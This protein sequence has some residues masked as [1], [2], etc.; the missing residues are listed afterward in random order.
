MSFI[1]KEDRAMFAFFAAVL[2]LSL[3][4]LSLVELQAVTY[5]YHYRHSRAYENIMIG[6]LYLLFL[7]AALLAL[8]AVKKILRWKKTRSAWVALVLLALAAFP[9]YYVAHD[10]YYSWE[11]AILISSTVVDKDAESCYVVLQGAGDAFLLLYGTPTEINLLDVGDHIGLTEYRYKR[12]SY[13]QLEGVGVV[14]IGYIRQISEVNT[15]GGERAGKGAALPKRP[16]LY[17]S[18]SERGDSR[19]LK[20][21]VKHFL[22][23]Y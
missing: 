23:Q 15:W 5:F 14:Y 6:V 3:L 19:G 17:H 1:K 7:A 22:D 13:T 12:T 9:V 16:P 10:V 18:V 20:Q 4:L 21:A 11:D 8:A 2:A